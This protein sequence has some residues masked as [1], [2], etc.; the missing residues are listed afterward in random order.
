MILFDQHVVEEKFFYE[1]IKEQIETQKVK[2][3]MLLK[4]EII[5]FSQSEMLLYKENKGLFEKL[6]FE[7]E[8][9]GN[10]EIIIRKVPISINNKEL[11][12]QIVKDIIG[13]ISIDKKFK[14]LEEK[15]LDK[16]ASMSCKK[17]LKGGEELTIPQ[18]HKMIENLKRLKEPFNCPHGRPIML[19][20]S[21]KDLE[22]KF[23]R[24]I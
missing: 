10:N 19:K 15:T 17:S 20:Y 24:I 13:E 1:T 21:F 9:F 23:K 16:I 14:N 12:P 4:P 2:T 3:Q 7:I 18:M 5:N 11:N 22:K 8:E 6:G